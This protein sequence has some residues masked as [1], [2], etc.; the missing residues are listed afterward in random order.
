MQPSGYIIYVCIQNL[1]NKHNLRATSQKPCNE[2]LGQTLRQS[3]ATSLRRTLRLRLCYEGMSAA[4]ALRRTLRRRPGNTLACVK[5]QY[6]VSRLCFILCFKA[7]ALGCRLAIS[8][9][10]TKRWDCGCPTHAAAGASFRGKVCAFWEFRSPHDLRSCCRRCFLGPMGAF[11]D[12]YLIMLCYIEFTLILGCAWTV[13]AP[14][15]SVQ[16]VGLVCLSKYD[17]LIT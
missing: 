16:L 17:I 10:S 15:L 7:C 12:F 9:P 11:R 4:K 5:C 6:Y 2:T 13:V 14:F 1:I 8:T 3:L